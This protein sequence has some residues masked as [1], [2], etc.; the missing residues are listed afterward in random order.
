MITLKYHNGNIKYFNLKNF[1]REKVL[2]DAWYS[3]RGEN[4]FNDKRFK[5]TT[6]ENEEILVRIGD[7]K[8]CIFEKSEFV[9]TE[10][11]NLKDTQEK[12]TDEFKAFMNSI[13]KTQGQRE[14]QNIRQFISEVRNRN[15]QITT[16]V[17]KNDPEFIKILDR[18]KKDNPNKIPFYANL[19]ANMFKSTWENKRWQ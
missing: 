4:Q 18:V 14:E 15:S 7:I 5:V 17:M 19:Y 3:M 1:E 2:Y 12:P 11:K 8:N 13:S 10:V 6:T 9:K 16:E